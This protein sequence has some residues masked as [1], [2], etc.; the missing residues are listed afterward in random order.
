MHD[1]KERWF[2]LSPEGW[3]SLVIGLLR[4]RQIEMALDKLDQMHNDEIVVQPWLYDIFTYMLC[5]LGEF[6]EAYSILLYR[7]EQ[8]RFG[9]SQSHWQYLLDRFSNASHVSTHFL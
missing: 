2:G 4:D 9:I 3:H 5:E 1:M 6:D 7:Y 8:A